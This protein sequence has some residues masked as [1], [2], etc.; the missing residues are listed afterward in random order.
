MNTLF[1]V[2]P[3]KD[4]FGETGG[5]ALRPAWIALLA[6]CLGAGVVALV[7]RLRGRRKR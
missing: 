2:K 3:D 5:P 1:E 4:L 6:G 7:R